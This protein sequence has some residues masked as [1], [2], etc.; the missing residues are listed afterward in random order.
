MNNYEY[1]LRLLVFI[2]GA[3]ITSY[4]IKNKYETN[5]AINKSIFN[6]IVL[7]IIVFSSIF[8][9]KG[10]KPIEAM[11]H[12]ELISPIFLFGMFNT[13]FILF[14]YKYKNSKKIN[15]SNSL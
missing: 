13:I 8:I 10:Y 1:L 12:Y 9:I 5:K 6:M 11:Q 15:N 4:S 14:K 7:A 2:F 3:V